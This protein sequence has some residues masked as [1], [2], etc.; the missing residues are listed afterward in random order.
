MGEA[1]GI[2]GYLVPMERKTVAIENIRQS[3][4]NMTDG[5]SR[6]LLR[7]VYLHF[8]CMLLETPR[9]V[10]LARH[11]L[12]RYVIFENPEYL[13]DA[14]RKGKGVFILAAHFGNWEL[15]AAAVTIRWGGTAM[16][17]RPAD[18]E[19]LNRMISEMRSR[20]GAI[21]IPKQ[22]AMKP[23]L[24]ALKQN[25]IIGILLDQNV[26]WY[27][28]VFV[29]FLGRWACTNKGLALITARTGTPVIPAFCVRAV[30]GRH[31]IIFEK[32]L[33]LHSTADKAADVE[34]NTAIFTRV[35]E[36]YVLEHPDH[37]FWF[38]KRWKTRNYCEWRAER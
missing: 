27:E 10:K 38:H 37:W 33:S 34:E 15:M 30:D 22:H 26:D 36:R 25:R 19:P 2:L 13:D 9:I 32:E 18:Y 12:H 3:F 14:L 4:R 31:R 24:Q 20:H 1:L 21:V 6:R 16:I 17:A 11:N 7:R 5:E 23:I 28:G 29:P 35:I 8:G